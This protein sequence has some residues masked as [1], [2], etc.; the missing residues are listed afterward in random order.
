[1]KRTF[2]LGA[3]AVIATVVAA[4]SASS[5]QKVDGAPSVHPRG[6]E[7]LGAGAVEDDLARNKEIVTSFYNMVFRDHQV[8]DGFAKYVGDRYTQHNP[9]V[10]DGSAA[11]IGF[12]VPYFAANP[13]AKSEIKRVIAE[14]DLVVLHVHARQRA[15]DPGRAIVDIFRVESGKIVEHWDVIQAVPAQAANSNTMF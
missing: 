8:A 4:V 6:R 1:M 13:E 5:A 2:W 7:I 14:G 9:L 15:D 3:I 12:F 10:P 11:A